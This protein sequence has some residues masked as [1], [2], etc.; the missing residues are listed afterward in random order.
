LES[1]PLSAE[2][3]ARA[4]TFA[5]DALAATGSAEDDV[6][7]R[8]LAAAVAYAVVSA[9]GVPLTQS[10]VAAPFRVSVARLRGRL[11]QLR[12][13]LDLGRSKRV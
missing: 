8:G 7:M 4:R 2:Q 9:D 5:R 3:R 1:L 10:E 12:T 6:S 13:R 11:A